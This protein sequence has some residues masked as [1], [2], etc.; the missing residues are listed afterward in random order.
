MIALIAEQKYAMF[1]Q[2]ACILHIIY[3]LNNFITNTFP[4]LIVSRNQNWK[5]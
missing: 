2:T 1:K 5:P 4:L 3:D